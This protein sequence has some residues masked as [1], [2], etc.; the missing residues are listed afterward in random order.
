MKNIIKILAIIFGVV[1]FDQLSKG[2][3]VYLITGNVP[4]YGAA[5]DV[6][7]VPYLM[8]Q[9]TNFLNIVFTWNP[10]TSFS[11]FRTL[12]ESLPIIIIAATSL[13]IGFLTHY[14]FYRAKNDEKLALSFIV[15]GAFGNLI[16]RLRFGAVIDFIDLHFRAWHW[17]AFNLADAFIALG[18]GLF[19]LNLIFKRKK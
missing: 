4:L 18:V 16:D 1:I 7:P 6:V 9:I 11:L 3:L 17:P 15:G 13:I 8:T 2:F 19:I 14:L 5:F 10:G 12:G